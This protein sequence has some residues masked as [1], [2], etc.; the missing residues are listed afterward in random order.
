MILSVHF[1]VCPWLIYSFFGPPR[2]IRSAV[3]SEFHR[4]GPDEIRAPTISSRWNKG[5][6]DSTL[7]KYVQQRLIL[8]T[9][10][11]GRTRTFFK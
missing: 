8:A 6:K 10:S 9:D 1:S 3:T 7:I 2:G 11:H 4:A 5:N